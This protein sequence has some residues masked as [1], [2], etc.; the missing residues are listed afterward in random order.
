MQLDERVDLEA[1]ER[2]HDL[3]ALAL[4]A[5]ALDPR[6]SEQHRGQGRVEAE[7]GEDL[8]AV[9]A[10]L[11]QGVELRHADLL[12]ARVVRAEQPRLDEAPRHVRP[13]HEQLVEAQHPLLHGE[14]AQREAVEHVHLHAR[15]PPREPHVWRDVEVIGAPARQRVPHQPAALQVEGAVDERRVLPALVLASEVE[16]DARIAP[17]PVMDRGEQHEVHRALGEEQDPFSSHVELRIVGSPA[18]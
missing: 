11:H 15:A 16:L 18:R 9:E 5:A 2:A 17:Q 12:D 4:E 8:P 10:A 1:A 6:G 14:V 13:D 3:L 7:P